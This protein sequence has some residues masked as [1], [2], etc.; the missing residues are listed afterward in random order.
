MLT[1]SKKK[2]IENLKQKHERN[3]KVFNELISTKTL[4]SDKVTSEIFQTFKL[5]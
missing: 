3:S 5:G 4:L 2:K 1:T